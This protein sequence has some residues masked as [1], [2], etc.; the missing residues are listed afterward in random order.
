MT[1]SRPGGGSSVPARADVELQDQPTIL[2]YYY[3][4][5]SGNGLEATLT[6]TQRHDVSWLVTSLLQGICTQTLVDMY[7]K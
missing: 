6:R 7:N 2:T 5:A 3:A 4:L 1:W